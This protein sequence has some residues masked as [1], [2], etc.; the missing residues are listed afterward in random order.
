[1]FKITQSKGFQMTFANGYGISV[2]WVYGNYCD[3]RDS[4]TWEDAHYR[5]HTIKIGAKGSSTA[6]IAILDL[7]GSVHDEHGIL[8]S[9]DDVEGWCAPE[10]VLEVMN[11]VAAIV[12]EPMVLEVLEAM[13]GGWKSD[14]PLFKSLNADEIAGYKQWARDSYVLGSDIPTIWHP[15]IQAECKLMN[16]EQSHE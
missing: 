2:Q 3:N 15:V 12:T 11:K 16:E 1:M 14:N 5:E 9:G 7:N 10:R 4:V 13:E 6:E 8:N